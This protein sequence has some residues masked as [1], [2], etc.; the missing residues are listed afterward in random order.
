MGPDAIH[1]LL[2]N[3]KLQLLALPNLAKWG[4]L[5]FAG[6]IILREAISFGWELRR[7]RPALPDGEVGP[8]LDRATPTSTPA[9]ALPAPDPLAEDLLRLRQ[10]ERH[11][12]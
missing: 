4:L 2:F 1:D 11:E 10:R 6:I 5:T 7:R 12:R 8:A 9:A 3:L